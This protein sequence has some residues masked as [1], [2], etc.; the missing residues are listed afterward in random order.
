[1]RLI[2][3]PA[4]R[5]DSG[6]Y[7]LYRMLMAALVISAA[8]GLIMQDV[9]DSVSQV[10]NF[11]G[12]VV[13]LAA[14]LGGSGMIL[15]ALHLK[16]AWLSL[17]LERLG[18][19]GVA[20]NAGIYSVAVASEYGLPVAAATWGSMA[21]GLYC[22]YRGIYEVPKELAELRAIALEHRAEGSAYG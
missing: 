21:L 6:S 13:Y 11:S 17:Q 7:P 14:Q 18:S 1:M 22:L 15:V 19:V 2:T 8:L 5:V 4:R 20:T 10:T 16:R 9:P 3:S 12:H